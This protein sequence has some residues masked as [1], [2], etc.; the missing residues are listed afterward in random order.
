MAH[1]IKI[2]KNVF[3]VLSLKYE[4]QQRGKKIQN[5]CKTTISQNIPF[6]IQGEKNLAFISSWAFKKEKHQVRNEEHE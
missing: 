5:N 3:S 6:R 2:F 1:F 4:N